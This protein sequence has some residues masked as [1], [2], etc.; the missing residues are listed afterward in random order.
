[1]THHI[2]EAQNLS[3]SYPDSTVGLRE[4]SFRM[5][6]G[7]S[8]ALVGDNGAGK[9]TLLLQLTGCLLPASGTVRINGVP[10]TKKNLSSI[11]RTVGMVFQD[12][13]DQLFMPTVLED[14]AFGPLNLGMPEDEALQKAEAALAEAGVL[15]LKHRPPYKLSGGEKRAVSIASALALSPDILLLDEPSSNLDARNRRRLITLL[16]SFSRAKII[17]THD[18]DLAVEVCSRALL[19]KQGRIVADGP[20]EDVFREAAASSKIYL[21]I[22]LGLQRCPSCNAELKGLAPNRG[23]PAGGIAP[24]KQKNT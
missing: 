17:A 14:A 4:V 16:Q 24:E 11:R 22:P 13:D 5:S 2:V 20:I 10:V 18:L 7:E 12:P 8:A 9:S 3:F 21:E 23:A 15:H 6:R 1:M 19:M